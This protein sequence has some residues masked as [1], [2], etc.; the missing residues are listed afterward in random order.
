MSK[1]YFFTGFVIVFVLVAAVFSAR[2]AFQKDTSFSPTGKV[3]GDPSAPIKISTWSDF[4]CPSCAVAHKTVHH[5]M[6]THPG[7][8]QIKFNH[9]PLKGHQ[10]AR[11]A[12]ISAECAYRLGNF[13]PYHDKL[14]DNQ[15][16]WSVLQD[17]TDTFLQYAEEIGF[18]RSAFQACLADVA[19]EKAVLLEKMDGTKLQIERTPT[20]FVNNERLV[21][22]K[23]LEAKLNSLLPKEEEKSVDG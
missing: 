16:K 6:E 5:F 9:F 4:Q 12:H 11:M 13:W 17:P 15:E 22:G 21:G 7:M 19:A 1:K 14:Y 2:A 10:H 23:D 3:T 8:A 20:I 18:S